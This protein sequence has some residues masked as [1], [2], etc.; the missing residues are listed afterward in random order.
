MS[1]VLM[2][3]DLRILPEYFNLCT[4]L[5]TELAEAYLFRLWSW[6]LKTKTMDGIVA[7]DANL[8]ARVTEYSGDPKVIFDALVS[9][10]WLVPQ[11]DGRYYIRGWATKNGRYLR[12][13]KRLAEKQARYRD[14]LEAERQAAHEEEIRQLVTPRV[15]GNVTPRVT[16]PLPSRYAD[17]VT[18]TDPSTETQSTSKTTTRSPVP[19]PGDSLGNGVVVADIFGD[20]WSASRVLDWAT[21]QGM[22][23]VAK[24][25]LKETL[26]ALQPFR[27]SD[28][29][30]A[31]DDAMDVFQQTHQ[32]PNAGLFVS[33]L[34]GRV[35]ER[36]TSRTQVP[37]MT[38]QE[39]A[40]K[41]SI[42]FCMAQTEMREFGT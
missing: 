29:K 16:P 1:N 33:K 8:V 18:T 31:Y 39:I 3:A 32:R 6:G 10:R 9:N 17:P 5:K 40:L 2:N 35:I 36:Q 12:E 27:P 30:G 4:A 22:K 14:R 42:E 41:R 21:D 15:T 23:P 25:T 26:V 28:V 13:G 11:E 37:T 7:L 38:K 20:P 19:I 24:S 34:L